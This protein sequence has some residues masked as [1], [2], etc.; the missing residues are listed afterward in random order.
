MVV[1][2]FYGT[3][4]PICISKKLGLYISNLPNTK[5]NEWRDDLAEELE[6]AVKADIIYQDKLGTNFPCGFQRL[7]HKLFPDVTPPSTFTKEHYLRV[8]DKMI[9]IYQEYSYED[10]PLG[11]WDTNCFDGRFCEE[12]YSEKLINFINFVTHTSF[13]DARLPNHVPQWVFSSNHNEI[14]HYRI[15][16]GGDAADEYISSLKKWGEI[17]DAFLQ[18]KNDFLLFDYLVNAIYKDNEY[19]EYHLLKAFT[20]CQLFLETDNASIDKRIIHFMD[21]SLSKNKRR[22]HARFFRQMRNAIAH[23]NF[24][25]LEF[26]LEEYAQKYMDGNFSFDYSEYSRKNW[27]IQHVCCILDSIVRQLICVLLLDRSKLKLP[28]SLQRTARFG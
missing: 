27:I 14:D 4:A 26:K 15:F 12:D 18:T 20:L 25:E 6:L 13:Q 10:M 22:N 3:I 21:S 5:H 17:L 8:A 11:G 7:Y 9:C 2:N 28:N 16:W 19:N 24:L 23:G 1:L